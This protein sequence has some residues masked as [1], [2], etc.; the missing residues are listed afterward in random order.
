MKYFLSRKDLTT[1]ATCND[2]ELHYNGM[3]KE[4]CGKVQFR[5][6][7]NYFT[8]IL[9]NFK[10]IS[11]S[12]RRLF[13]AAAHVQY[14]SSLCNAIY[15]FQCTRAEMQLHKCDACPLGLKQLLLDHTFVP[16]AGKCLK[17]TAC[18]RFALQ[19]RTSLKLFTVTHNSPKYLE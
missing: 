16:S 4:A 7:Q 3:V 18:A 13:E 9:R 15:Q 6:Q 2:Q 8:I 11:L 14:R 5:S 17:A 10:R 1:V 19:Y 12:V